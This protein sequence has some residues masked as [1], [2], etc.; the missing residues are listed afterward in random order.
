MASRLGIKRANKQNNTAAVFAHFTGVEARTG[1]TSGYISIHLAEDGWFWMIPLPGAVMSV[2]FVGNQAA[3]K[4]RSGTLA[5][6]LS[7]RLEASPTVRAR[8]QGAERIS[9]VYSAGNYSY[10]ADTASGEGW[11]MIGDAFAFIDPVFSSGVLLAMTSGER[12][13]DVAC[14]WLDN[15]EAGRAAA[16][17][18]EA[19]QRA[20]MDG[21][22]WLI[23][24]IN[25]PVLRSMFMSPRNT[26]RMREGVITLLAGNLAVDWRSRLPVL[27]LKSTYHLLTRR[28]PAWMAAEP[29]RRRRPLTQAGRDALFRRVASRYRGSGRFA[30]FYVASKLRHDPVH[31]ALLDLAASERFRRRP[32]SRLRARPAWSRPARSRRGAL[33]RWPRLERGPPRPGIAGGTQCR[34]PRRVPRSDPA[35]YLAGS[36]HGADHRHAVPT[37]H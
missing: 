23:Y 4:N 21:I 11:M 1:E 10:R 19:E 20:M 16:R 35:R 24:R 12:G 15:P 22:S 37:R 13:A 14:T 32:R 9:D 26:L 7:A 29:A 30:R 18:A 3:F 31:R 2:G 17:R 28:T 25:T 6:L 34:V 5:D 33:C 36:G 8:M 27:A